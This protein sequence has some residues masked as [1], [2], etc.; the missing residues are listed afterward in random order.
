MNRYAV[1]EEK[2]DKRFHIRLEGLV[3]SYKLTSYLLDREHGSVFDEWVRLGTPQFLTEEELHY[4]DARSG[5][6]MNTQMIH[7]V[8]GWQQEVTLS[9]HGVMLLTFARQY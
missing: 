4:L 5:P 9:P 8:Q 3:G 6:V 1:F 7:G 2:G